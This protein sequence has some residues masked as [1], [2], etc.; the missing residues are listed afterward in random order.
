MFGESNDSSA[1][2]PANFLRRLYGDNSEKLMPV[3]II[4]PHKGIDIAAFKGEI[5]QKLR[6]MR[7]LKAGEIDNFFIN[8][9]SGFTDLI[10]GI[11][12]QMNVIGW[13]VD[14]ES[15]ISCLFPLRNEPT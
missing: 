9:L 6:N 1:F 10:D 11:V 15:P 13:M 2:F 3:I 7:G 5:S 12:S 4:K 14:L 8:I